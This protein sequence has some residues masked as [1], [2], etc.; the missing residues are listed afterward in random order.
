MPS[1]K[2]LAFPHKLSKLPNLY[3]I[4][5]DAGYQS[6]FYYGGNLEFANIK[7]LFV[8]GGTNQII[9]QKEMKGLPSET[10]LT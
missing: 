7:S 6:S 10:N 4:A 5:N 9:T 1:K 3:K 2:V 8:S